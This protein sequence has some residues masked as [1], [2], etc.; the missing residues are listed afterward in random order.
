MWSAHFSWQS[1]QQW[2]ACGPVCLVGAFNVVSG[3]P[4][5]HGD[6]L[7]D[8]D[9]ETDGLLDKLRD[10]VDRV[11]DGGVTAHRR[12]INWNDAPERTA[13]EVIDVLRR[14]A[15]GDAAP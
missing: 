10:A 14:V 13:D 9:R 3:L 1:P 4:V 12:L 8:R 15:A 5:D 6:C 7:G 2:F 11:T